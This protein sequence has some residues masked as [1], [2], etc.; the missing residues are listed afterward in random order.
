M[1]VSSQCISFQ[2]FVLLRQIGAEKALLVS[3][4]SLR[5]L[6]NVSFQNPL[7][8]LEADLTPRGDDSGFP[9]ASHYS[10]RLLP[11]RLCTFSTP[12]YTTVISYESHQNKGKKICILIQLLSRFWNANVQSQDFV[13]LIV[14][15]LK[16]WCWSWAMLPLCPPLNLVFS[17]TSFW[18]VPELCSATEATDSDFWRVCLKFFWYHRFYERIFKNLCWS[19]VIVPK[20]GSSLSPIHQWC[21]NQIFHAVNHLTLSFPRWR[22]PIVKL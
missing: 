7:T 2:F 17:W 16:S 9:L 14:R 13:D 21:S 3:A 8:H 15:L 11:F 22:K 1:A 18:N 19:L 20:S 10:P 12:F 6:L 5:I 4:L